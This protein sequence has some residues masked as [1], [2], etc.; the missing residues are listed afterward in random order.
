MIYQ[1]DVDVLSLAQHHSKELARKLPSWVPDWRTQIY[2]PFS[3]TPTRS[4]LKVSGSA[5]FFLTID[6]DRL[7]KHQAKLLGYL[8]SHVETLGTKTWC[9]PYGEM[10]ETLRLN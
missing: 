4:S 1:G 7:P 6:H 8:L 5:S 3:Q 10:I 9:P 2:P